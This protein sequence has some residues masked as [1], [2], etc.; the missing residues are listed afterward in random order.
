MTLLALLV[1]V[2]IFGILADRALEE[3]VITSED[4]ERIREADEARDEVIRVDAFTPEEFSRL[5]G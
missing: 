2:L 5:R 1:A 3:G 4:R